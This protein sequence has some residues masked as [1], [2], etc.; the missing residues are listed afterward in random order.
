LHLD[1]DKIFFLIKE[2]YVLKKSIYYNNRLHI[3]WIGSF[4]FLKHYKYAQILCIPNIQFLLFIKSLKEYSLAS[5]NKKNMRLSSRVEAQKRNT[6]N[7]EQGA[8]KDWAKELKLRNKTQ[9]TLNKEVRK[10]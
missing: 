9:I 3:Q 1:T 8:W 7:T 10:C 4:Q 2:I 5:Q 6:N